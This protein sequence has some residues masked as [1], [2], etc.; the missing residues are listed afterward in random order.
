MK[1]LTELIM[2]LDRSGS[3]AGLESD[4]VGGYN[5]LIEE[6]KKEPGEALVTAV[7]FDDRA[8]LLYKRVPVQ[9]VPKLTEKE[10]FVRGCTS[11]MLD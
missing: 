5:A 1:N 10:Y 11:L 2:I 3:M 9:Q 8:E 4:T 6:Q 7:L